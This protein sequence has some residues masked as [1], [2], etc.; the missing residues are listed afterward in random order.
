MTAPPVALLMGLTEELDRT[1][2][3]YERELVDDIST[4]NHGDAE[5]LRLLRE[6]FE[7]RVENEIRCWKDRIDLLFE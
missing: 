6:G 4:L 3:F 5:G 1:I 2:Q 7:K